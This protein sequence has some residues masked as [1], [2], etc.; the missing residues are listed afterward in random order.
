[1]PADLHTHC[2]VHPVPAHRAREALEI[3]FSHVGEGASEGL[4][5]ASY[6]HLVEGKVSMDGLWGAWRDKQLVGVVLGEVIP[7]RT[8]SISIPR[9]LID[10]EP[11]VRSALL[12]AVVQWCGRQDVTMLQ[13]LHESPTGDDARLFQ[14][15]GFVCLTHMFYLVSVPRART[16]S[17]ESDVELE[18]YDRAQANRL[19]AILQETYQGTLDCP[20]LNGKRSGQDILDGYRS[21]G[22]SG[23]S[24]WYFVRLGGREVG[25]V[26]LADHANDDQ[27]EL[28]YMALIPDVRRKGLGRT[29]VQFAKQCAVKAGR[30]KLTAAVDG[31]NKPA[32]ACYFAGGFHVWGQRFIFIK[33]L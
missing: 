11:I 33:F 30:R 4:I 3:L 5:N 1:M 9:T 7:G 12:E 2:Q 32:L 26:L 22:N 17:L 21:V 27:M 25:C 20:E 18:N 15:M 13:A 8:A 10:A 6:S 24:Y 19:A 31:R 16:T 28:V 14:Q 29:L 23:D